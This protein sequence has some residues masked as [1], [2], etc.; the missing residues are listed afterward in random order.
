MYN[1][2]SFVVACLIIARALE[3]IYSWDLISGKDRICGFRKIRGAPIPGVQPRVAPAGRKGREGTYSRGSIG[4]VLPHTLQKVLPGLQ[5]RKAKYISSQPTFG[6]LQPRPPFLHQTDRATVVTHF[7]PR[8]PE[9]HLASCYFPSLLCA[10]YSVRT[11][12]SNSPSSVLSDA[13]SLRGKTQSFFWG[14]S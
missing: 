9:L 4:W 13:P 11:G 2:L 3:N 5:C 14:W 10:S 1:A 12:S 7:S 8:N 6:Q